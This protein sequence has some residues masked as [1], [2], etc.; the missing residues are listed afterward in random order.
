MEFL[1]GN[2]TANGI[3]FHYLEIG[4]GPLVLCLHGFPDCAYTY[5]YLLPVVA[6]AGFRG[7]APF[8][9]GYAP[10]SNAPDGRYDSI[11]L[12]QDA[13]ALIGALGAEQAFVV[14]HD[15]GAL[16]TY[17]A[18][19]FAPDRVRKIATLGAAFG[20]VLGRD[21]NT[22]KGMW[23][24]FFFQMPFADDLVA[25]NDYDFITGWWHDASPEYD[26]PAEVI[27]QVKMSFRQPG[28]V[29]AALNYY[30]HTINPA[31][32]DPAL[33]S[34]RRQIADALI[35]VPTISFHGTK[36]RPGRL[37]GFNR[38]DRYFSAGLEKIVL[39][40]A[41]HFVHLERPDQVNAK[42]VEFFKK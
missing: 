12:G 1:T 11:L 21:Y 14:G 35:A 41:G 10:T 5:R 30:R 37:E 29:T 20:D 4:T 42:I 27:E 23:H 36:D 8:M 26:P 34:L 9:R 31:S 16:A 19:I 38:M 32:R 6:A 2:V 25:D 24:G 28:V 33:E 40:G 17:E 13:V 15:W 18:A 22:L 7:V 3:D 39:P